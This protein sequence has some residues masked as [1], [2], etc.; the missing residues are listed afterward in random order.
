MKTASVIVRSALAVVFAFVMSSASCDLFDKVDDVTFDVILDHTFHVNEEEENPDGKDYFKFE[1]LDAADVNSD[2]AK[3]KDKIKSITVTG[4]T[5]TIQNCQTEGV[6][7][8]DGFVGFSA[9]SITA[10]PSQVASVGIED[11][12]AAE[13][14]EKNL[15]Y[16]QAAIDQL[17]NLL[18]DDKKANLFL[19]GSFSKTPAQFDVNVTVKASI[20]ADAL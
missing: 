8:N 17:S 4:V 20:T 13:N 16:S 3:Y 18:K 12:K 10:A 1:V 15:P 14:K 6:I 2:F 9:A 5:Y 7:F 11:I 19:L